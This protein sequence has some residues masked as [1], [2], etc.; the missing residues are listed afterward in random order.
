MILPAIRSDYRAI[1]TYRYEPGRQ[2]D[3]PVTV[4]TG[5]SDPRVSID[6]AAAWKE[7]TTGPTDLQVLPGGHFFLVEQSERVVELLAE[8]LDRQ[9]VDAHPWAAGHRHQ[10]A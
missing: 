10:G 3:C 6:E 8:K 1:E 4:L 2:L 9:G 5:D 7:H